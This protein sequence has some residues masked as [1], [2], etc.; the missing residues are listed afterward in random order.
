M[1]CTKPVVS[2]LELL[3]N[4]ILDKIV[5]SGIFSSKDV[6]FMCISHILF[7]YKQVARRRTVSTASE[8]KLV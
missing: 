7:K 5:T 8:K 3:Q 4:L 2:S 6:D 1:I